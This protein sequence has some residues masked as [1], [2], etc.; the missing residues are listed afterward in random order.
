MKFIFSISTKPK[1]TIQEI[2]KKEIDLIS[3][4]N[5][6]FFAAPKNPTFSGF[7]NL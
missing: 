4:K 3:K 1:N 6:D 2:N 5:E 7:R